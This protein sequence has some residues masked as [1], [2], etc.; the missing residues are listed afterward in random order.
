MVRFPITESDIAEIVGI[1]I[2]AAIL[3]WG[4]TILILNL[5]DPSRIP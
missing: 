4:V 3:T 5:F 2:I 1:T